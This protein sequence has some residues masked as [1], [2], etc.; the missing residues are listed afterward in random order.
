[1]TEVE[2]TRVHVAA[3]Q[4]L[5]ADKLHVSPGAS[6]HSPGKSLSDLVSCFRPLPNLLLRW[7]ADHPR[8]HV[9]VDDTAPHGY[10]AG[11]Q[12]EGSKTLENVVWLSAE[13]AG[14]R[15]L[16]LAEAAYL[17]NHLLG[18]HG[19]MGGLWLSD[20]GGLTDVWSQ[21]GRR[22]HENFTL[23][24]APD[25]AAVD[26]H[27]YFSW[28]LSTY[29]LDRRTL[30]MIDPLLERLL[31]TTILC[32]DFWGVTPIPTAAAPQVDAQ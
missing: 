23:G 26:P 31:R 17:L 16:V 19:E 4:R 7:W 22:L 9:V 25:A 12:T 3:L 13:A 2:A 18:C 21:V 29:M 20:G 10:V 24:Y 27:T 11:P 14:N 1:M 8:G 30:N 32:N 6:E 28:G 5:L 15:S